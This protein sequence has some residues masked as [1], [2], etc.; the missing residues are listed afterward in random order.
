[1]RK[2]SNASDLNEPLIKKA[3]APAEQVPNPAEEHILIYMDG[4]ISP[5]IYSPNIVNNQK[6]TVHN[7][8][9]KVL[10]N[11]F[12]Y[13]FNLFFLLIALSQFIP[14]LK[15][16]FLFSYVAPLVFVLSVTMIN[17]AYDDYKRYKRDM[18]QNQQK[19]NI[20]RDGSTYEI[21]ACELKPG[22]LVEVRANQRVPADLV[23]ICTSEE[24]GTVF[25]R[26]D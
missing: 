9:P 24:D 11:Q 15:V 26:T 5:E 19:Y 10:Y 8:V 17:E 21:N 13:F 7:F 3:P 25:I 2:D 22:D 16:G 18:E 6:Y 20:K 14:S 12:K 1:M 4:R 23:L